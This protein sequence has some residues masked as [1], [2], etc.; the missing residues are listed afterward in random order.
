MSSQEKK[1][2]KIVYFDLDQTALQG[3]EGKR[4]TGESWQI[5][6]VSL[7]V[8]KKK[9]ME[10]YVNYLDAI[11]GNGKEDEKTQAK[12]TRDIVKLWQDAAKKSK[13]GRD[14]IGVLTKT[15]IDQICKEIFEEQIKTEV[16]ETMRGLIKLGIIPIISTGGLATVAKVVS[17]IIESKTAVENT[18]LEGVE[19][20]LGNSEFIYDS[21]NLLNGF[22]HDHKLAER[23]QEQIQAKINEIIKLVGV[24]NILSMAV[25]DG[26][27]D[28]LVFKDMPG[29]AFNSNDEELIAESIAEA[30]SWEETLEI[31]LHFFGEM[32][33]I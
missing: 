23:K 20:H 22:T 12:M 29:I 26:S 32:E 19:L 17:E 4:W 25:S 6:A 13:N 2:L 33:K 1:S 15:K 16:L 3:D 18:G 28:R 30:A 8:D 9:H 31:L 21:N 7:G 5:L 27:S 24:G 10:I 11:T 14:P